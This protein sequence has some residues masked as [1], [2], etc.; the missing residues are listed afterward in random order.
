MSK[1]ELFTGLSFL[2]HLLSQASSCC[3]KM[4]FFILADV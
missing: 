1:T 4:C 2:D 3:C